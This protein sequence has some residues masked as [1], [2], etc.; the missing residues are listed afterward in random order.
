[1][2]DQTFISIVVP[3]YNEMDN[4][5]RL[6]FEIDKILSS[7]IQHEIII[8]NDGST[9]ETGNITCSLIP[10]YPQLK[11]LSLS[12]NQGQQFAI[13]QGCKIAA[14]ACVITIDADLQ[15]PP[16]MIPF[17]MNKWKAGSAI[18]YG[19]RKKTKTWSLKLFGTYCYY[20]LLLLLTGF[21]F[22]NGI[23]DFTLIDKK[24]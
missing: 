18:V 9:D 6:V 21:S 8:L 14:G 10:A 23:S 19:V 11:Y 12:A 13:L 7:F 5:S 17:M 20:K 16:S 3:A 24:I 15:Q 2:T 1:M 22:E 4:I